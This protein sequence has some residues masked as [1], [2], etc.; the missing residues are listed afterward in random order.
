MT[1]TVD[2]ILAKAADVLTV[3]NA[4]LRF[5]ATDEMQAEVGEARKQ[6][7]AGRG[8]DV[9][10]STRVRSGEAMASGRGG[11]RPEGAAR[12]G[13]MGAEDA[14]IAVAQLW[15]VDDVGQLRIARVRTGL[16]DGQV[17]EISGPDLVDGM[18]VVAA[19]T[20]GSTATSSNAN[21]FQGQ[22]Q[23]ARRGPPSG[24]V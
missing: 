23:E 8:A 22:Q 21:P 24:G 14:G 20:S 2:F 11:Q 7:V 3:P 1:A 17:T 15:Y 16:T 19:V 10:D 5:R 18:F 4:A 9:G 6:D 13:E 12:P